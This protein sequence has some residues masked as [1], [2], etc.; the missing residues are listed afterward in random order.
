MIIGILLGIS[1]SISITSLVLILTTATGLIAENP[2]TGAAIGTTTTISYASIALIIS[3]I[4]TYIL[5][6]ILKKS[7]EIKEYPATREPST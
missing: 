6:F 1:I 2:A 5:I 3:L 4:T 7:K